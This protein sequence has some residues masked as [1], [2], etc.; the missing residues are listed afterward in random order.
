MVAPTSVDEALLHRRQQRV[1]LRLVE[2]VDLVEEED[3]ALA[4]RRAA[5]LGALDHVAHL[6]AAGVDGRR[7]LERR[8]RVHGEQAG[9]RGLAG[10]GR[11]VQDHRV[12][13][14]PP[15]S[16]CAAP[17]PRPSRCSCPTNSPSDARP[18]AHRER[19]LRRRHRRAAARAVVISKRRSTGRVWQ[20]FRR[21]AQPRLYVSR[22]A[23]IGRT[24]AAHH[25]AAPA[26]D[27]LQH[28]EPAGQ[29]AGGTGVP[30]RAARGRGLRVRA[31]VRGGGTPEPDR[32]PARAAPT[33]RASASS[34]TWTPCSPTRPSGAWTRGRAS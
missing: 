8:A 12:R 28:G 34:A 29:R 33:A 3:R 2:A 27:P 17:S 10:A 5:V 15:R 25:R 32:A 14:G 20:P 11:P 22:R 21:S 24:R 18:H 23:R 4:A 9:E 26:A 19:L 31:A 16:R 1:L 13:A 7:L 30:A 6:G